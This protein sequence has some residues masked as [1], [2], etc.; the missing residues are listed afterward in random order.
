[1]PADIG[2][3]V[4]EARRGR[5]WTQA[6]LAA[7]ADLGRETIYRL[8][9][10]RPPTV[11]TVLR[12]EAALGLTS[13]HFAPEW[14]RDEAPDDAGLGTRTRHRRRQLGL[15]LEAC[16]VAADVSTTTLSR[17]ER[18]TARSPKLVHVRLG[19]LPVAMRNDG[20]AQ[21]LGFEDSAEM[22]RYCLN[23]SSNRS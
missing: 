19:V 20:L 3:K 21:I 14:Q 18:L 22:T 1:M 16:A 13:P 10:G 12:I 2:L 9:L 23:P 15:S 5:R 7:R 4:R 11:D 8:E 17:F 6:R